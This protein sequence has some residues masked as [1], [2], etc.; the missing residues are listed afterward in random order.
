[1]NLSFAE[2]EIIFDSYDEL[3]KYEIGNGRVNYKYSDR[4]VIRE[5][6]PNTGNGYI[7][8]RFLEENEYNINSRGWIKIKN[9]NEKQ[10]KNLLEEAMISFLLYL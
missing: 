6:N 8:G 1:M 7:C 10:I 3:Y 5:L 9:F 2:K 4:V